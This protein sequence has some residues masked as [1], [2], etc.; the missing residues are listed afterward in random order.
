MILAAIDIGSNALRLLIEE[1]FV[2]DGE[3]HFK[4]IALTRVPLRL[5]H[6]VFTSGTISQ[7][8]AEK[9]VKVMKAFRLLMEVNDVEKFRGCATSAMRE[10]SNGNEVRA[11]IKKEAK[12]NIELITGEE[13]A[14]LIFGNFK[15]TDFEIDKDKTYLYIDV[16]GGSTEVTL[17]KKNQ[18]IQS[19]SFNLGSVRLLTQPVSEAV[20]A[21]ACKK[22]SDMVNGEKDV[23]AIGTGGNINR[24]YKESVHSFGENIKLTEIKKIIAFI[25]QFSYNDRIKKLKLKPDRADVIVPAGRIYTTF[26][27]AANSK[28][29]MVPKVGLADGIIYKMFEDEMVSSVE[30]NKS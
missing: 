18:R 11:L 9:L 12:V 2:E 25:E 8:K 3:I 6:D 5:G 16:G 10:A 20:W 13:E 1:A 21:D 15:S 28:E 22:I 17:I 4:K 24:I 27:K 7:T 26:M 30:L 29:M 19:Y 23:I 14:D